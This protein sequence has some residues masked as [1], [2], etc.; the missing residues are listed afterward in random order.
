VGGQDTIAEV[1]AMMHGWKVRT[2]SGI[3]VEH[4]KPQFKA[5][6]SF[7]KAS[8][9]YA[10]QYYFLGYNPVYYILSCARRIFEEPIIINMI[11]RIV[12]FFCLSILS[13]KRPVGNGFI[14]EIRKI[15]VNKIKTQI[16]NLV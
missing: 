1:Y 13:Y 8:L 11:F 14:K 2:I 9:S 15:Q 10:K 6:K 12:F 16:R 3:V 4:L 7:V 5:R